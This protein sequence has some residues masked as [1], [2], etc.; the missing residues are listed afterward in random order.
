MKIMA[1]FKLQIYYDLMA[2]ESSNYRNARANKRESITCTFQQEKIFRIHEN[3]TYIRVFLFFQICEHQIKIF[4]NLNFTSILHIAQQSYYFK[5]WLNELIC[6][7]FWCINYVLNTSSFCV[8]EI[9]DSFQINKN[10]LPI[11]ST[12]Y[13]LI[14]IHF[15]N[16]FYKNN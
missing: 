13:F 15:K 6:F 7:Y 8:K 4:L 12:I 9:L 16:G 3:I 1:I 5:S 2:R 14:K 10:Q 11:L